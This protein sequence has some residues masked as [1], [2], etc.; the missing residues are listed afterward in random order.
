MKITESILAVILITFA[1][2]NQPL[3]WS[4]TVKAAVSVRFDSR[5]LRWKE[6]HDKVDMF[7]NV[8]TI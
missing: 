8:L 2:D 1:D 4:Y 6:V 5:K 3:S 7:L